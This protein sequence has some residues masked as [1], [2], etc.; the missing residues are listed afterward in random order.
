[1]DYAKHT[2]GKGHIKDVDEFIADE[3][4]SRR[5]AGEI[6]DTGLSAETI[7]RSRRKDVEALLEWLH[8]EVEQHASFARKE[9]LT[10]ADAAD[11]GELRKQLVQALSFLA[12]RDEKDIE[13]ALAD[14]AS[15]RDHST[16]K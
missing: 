9:G 5:Q 8:L 12:Q 7:Y 14:A 6:D 11:L 4:A 15:G 2:D 10:Y 3:Q 16:S 1:M 13:S